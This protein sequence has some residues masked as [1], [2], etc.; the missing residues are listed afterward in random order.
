M[1][2]LLSLFLILILIV[3][4]V[5]PKTSHGEEKTKPD[6]DLWNTLKP[7]DTTLSFL[8]TGAHPDDERSHL[9]AYLSRG[10]GIRTASLIANRGEGGQNEIGK[11]LGN[12]LGIIRS[13]E[14]IEASEVT[15][16]E[17]FHLSET[18]NDPIYDFGFSKSPEETLEKWGE[19]LTYERFIRKIRTYK[20]DI[21]F[22][23]FLDIDT[24]HGHHR[25]INQLTVR[26]FED[27]AD[28]NVFPKQLEEGLS[29]WQVKKL[30]LPAE[31]DHAT[32]LLEIGTYDPIYGMTYPQLG[33]KSRFLHKSQGM[34]D[35]IPAE[36]ET[37]NLRLAKSVT[38]IPK[39]ENMFDGLA[40]D[41][42][43]IAARLTDNNP[44]IGSKL[45]HFQKTLD[46]VIDQYPNRSQAL[47]KAHI[48]L[49]EA[50]KLQS[51]IQEANLET[52][53]KEDILFRLDVKEKQLLE[54]SKVASSLAVETVVEDVTLVQ[55][56]Q[57]TVTI[58]VENNGKHPL[59]DVQGALSLPKGW[60][61]NHTPKPF[62]LKAGEKKTIEY[63]VQVPEN[64]E[65]FEPYDE[66]KMNSKL[67]YSVGPTKVEQRYQ[68]ERTVAVLP[69]VSVQTDPT[70]LV[71]NTL[72]IPE[73]VNVKAEVQNNTSGSL[74]ASVELNV[75]EGW[76]VK[77]ES[78]SV[79]FSEEN[80]IKTVSFTVSPGTEVN[81]GEFSL[82][83]I[84]KTN[85]KSLSTYVQKIQYDHISTSYYL[86]QAKVKGVAFDLNLPDNL[87]VGYIDSGFD[88]VAERLQGIGMNVTKLGSEDLQTGDLSKYD[89][90]V[91]GVRAYLSREDLRNNN[92]RLL[93][94][95]EDGGHLVVQYNKPWDNWNP[96]QTAPYKLVIGQPSIEW[97]VTDETAAVD[98]QKP[99][100]P[101]FNFPNTIKEDDWSNWIQERGLYYPMEW[102]EK[103]ETFVSMADPNGEPFNGG[104]LMADYGEGSYL[105]TNL[106]WY[107]QIQ[108]QVPGG[109]RIFTNLVSYPLHNE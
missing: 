104:I 105:Y 107:R 24:Q 14:L 1:G 42:T 67:S 33:E 31:S 5:T 29:T 71:V 72:D 26:A 90:I 21:L 100:H 16:V 48:A 106:V 77:P 78:K 7:L 45:K 40:Y 85:G 17:V 103:F 79:N 96:E 60:T 101:L 91:T 32:T 55:D 62:R 84:V 8:N 34:G 98:V 68:T 30:Y 69:D 25:A 44:A 82:E 4:M 65:Y 23:S 76:T 97:R 102:D 89:T 36:P 15:G 81:K 95:A 6:V 66:P 86:Q 38:E 88:K 61:V 10:L 92:E 49:K 28:P 27:A 73:K 59:K 11:E 39:E 47:K 43:E 57:T 75:P 74:N 35:D 108:N 63:L 51:E 22:P 46:K 50:R 109:Y 99:D 70:K 19:E 58:V 87:K 94:Y 37:I 41:F 80:E 12:A 93:Q 3:P 56:G 20:P 2:K 9:L 64:A 18:T 13:N 83:P 52:N 53:I 54:V